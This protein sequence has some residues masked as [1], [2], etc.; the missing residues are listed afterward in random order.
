MSRA[1]GGSKPKRQQSILGLIE[2][3]RLSSQH[4]IRERLASLGIEATQSTISRDIEELGLARVHD[5]EG[6]RYMVPGDAGSHGPVVLLRHL[7]DEFALSFVA[8]D[9]GLIVRTSPGAAA[10]LAEGI[11]RAGLEQVAGTIAGDNTILVLGRVGVK[12]LA[13][14]RSLTHIMEAR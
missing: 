8:T 13:I 6:T 2:R 11:D 14:E 12:P 9:G 7:L 10:A 3:E 1:N 5:A 4:E